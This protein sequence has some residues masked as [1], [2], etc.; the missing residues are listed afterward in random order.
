[1]TIQRAQDANATVAGTP[2]TTQPGT[3]VYTE[4]FSNHTAASGAINVIG[5]TGGAAA[6][7]MSYTAD[8]QYTPAAGQ[9]NGWILRSTTPTP[10]TDLGCYNNQSTAWASL[11]DMAIQLGLAQGQT[12][13][14]AVANQALSESTNAPSGAIAA[15]TELKTAS[16]GGIPAVPGHYY[17]IS[18]YFA[19]ANCPAQGG[20]SIP[21]ETLSIIINGAITPLS[22]GLTPCTDLTNWGVQVKKLQSAAIQIPSGSNASLGLSIYNATAT[23]S[24]NDVAFDLPQIVDVT[25]QLDKAFS[26]ALIAPGQTSTVTLTVTNTSDL[27]AKTDWSITDA[28]PAGLV[29][30]P[31]PAAGGTCAQAA[32]NAFV[33]TAVAGSNVFSATGGDLAL[34]QAS[35]TLTFDVTAAAEGTYINGPGNITSNLNPPANATLT[36]RA[37]RITL[38]KALATPRVAATDQFTMAIRTGGASGTV[39]NST[40]NSTTTGAGS[41]VT[42]GTGT[43]GT[44]VAT[45][46][47]AYSLTE[48]S[49]GT[50]VLGN[51]SATISCTDIAGLQTG[52]PN[53]A[54]YNPAAPPTITPIAGVNI[55]C[56]IT[57]SALP[58]LSYSKDVDKGAGTLVNPGD[59]LTYTLSIVNSGSVPSATIAAFDD[60]TNVVSMASLNTSSI[61]ITPAGTGAATYDATTKKLT[62]TG[63]V[64]ANTTIRVSYTV[65]VNAGAFGQLRNAFMGKTV[66]NP[67]GASLQWRKIDATVAK[68]G[69]T[70]AT[71]TLTPVNGAGQPTGT[72]ITITDCVSTPC[73]V[74]D[75]DPAGGQFLVKGLVPGTYQLVETKAPSGYVLNPTPINVTVSAA[76]Q[77]TVL[78]DVVNQQAPPIVLPL[79]G[80]LGTDA[81]AYGATALLGLAAALIIWQLRRRPRLEEGQRHVAP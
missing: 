71:W 32:G 21:R 14:Q 61:T 35:C 8:W 39:V 67:I 59:T 38:N 34:N 57:N 23:G 62:W 64:P 30:A 41:T 63:I 29:I 22:S 66:T 70:G 73:T 74:A 27:M 17:A 52:L 44:Y 36:V 68:N 43:T 72:A 19:A 47:T 81:I 3:P 53:G 16:A 1:M 6:G 69:L 79:T 13:S 11:Q 77:T 75:T 7:N 50:T 26:P 25:P 2:G 42:A 76:T 45:T 58:I 80:G 33:R 18:G 46:G 10:M 20:N 12:S 48:A 56:T 37:P 5:Y 49:S 40:A 78:A 60:L 51:Y 54:V 24:G 9:C 65:T 4:D 31:N 55:A 15:G 28:L